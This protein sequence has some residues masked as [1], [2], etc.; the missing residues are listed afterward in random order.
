M[1]TGSGTDLVAYSFAEKAAHTIQIEPRQAGSMEW[2]RDL[3]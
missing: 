1:A 2:K 3:T